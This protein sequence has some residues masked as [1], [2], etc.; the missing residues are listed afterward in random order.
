MAL[1]KFNVKFDGFDGE[2]LSFKIPPESRYPVKQLVGEVCSY[3]EVG[4]DV[5]TLTVDKYINRRT[6][7]QNKLMW[8]L[9]EI[10]AVSL[11]GGRTGDG[12]SGISA[13]DCYADTLESFGAKYEY[14][15]CL[16]DGIPLLKQTFR[17]IKIMEERVYNGT[18]M[19]VLKCFYGSSKMNTE[20]MGQLIDGIFDRL[21][22]MGVDAK[23]Q[24]DI[25]YLITEWKKFK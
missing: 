2:T 24:P 3:I 22:L 15:M 12:E 10:M 21:S 4:K 19:K 20:E 5:F 23:Y 25:D 8:A 11:N 6:N 13:Y 18:N 7:Q 9:L 16:P 14:L 17:A 1:G